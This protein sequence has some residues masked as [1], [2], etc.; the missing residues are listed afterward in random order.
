MPATGPA[1]VTSAAAL[2]SSL[3][4]DGCILR[5]CSALPVLALEARRSGR[6]SA[7]ADKSGSGRG[8]GGTSTTGFD[9]GAYST[10]DDDDDDGGGGGGGNDD[11]GTVMWTLA[12]RTDSITSEELLAEVCV[13]VAAVA[14][15]GGGAGTVACNC[16]CG[17]G[18]DG[19]IETLAL[20]VNDN[21]AAAGVLGTLLGWC[22]CFPASPEGTNT[23]TDTQYHR[24]TMHVRRLVGC[25]RWAHLSR[26]ARREL[27]RRR[28]FDS[29]GTRLAPATACHTL[30]CSHWTAY[31]QHGPLQRSPG[32][33]GS[34]QQAQG[35]VTKPPRASTTHTYLTQRPCVKVS[36][37]TIRKAC[38]CQILL[39][40]LQTGSHFGCATD[41]GRTHA[42]W[43][44][45]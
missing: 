45:Q 2:A 29:T 7:N 11:G 23:N 10:C 18:C 3:A 27:C 24:S 28:G 39:V 6:G 37:H 17:S 44:L 40:L 8:N 5:G 34:L 42:S 1:A 4:S 30:S 15:R 14:G 35:S 22:T 41:S 26:W 25:R 36:E 13:S 19:A 20:G 9:T 32:P 16:G 33:H 31:A 43:R 38:S 12:V 21:E